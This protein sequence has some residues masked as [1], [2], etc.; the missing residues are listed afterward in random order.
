MIPSNLDEF[1]QVVSSRKTSN[2][3][4]PKSSSDGR[5]GCSQPGSS[6]PGE[7]R[8]QQPSVSN[9]VSST[10]TGTGGMSR[11]PPKAPCNLSPIDR[12]RIITE[13][14]G[15]KFI[16]GSPPKSPV[17]MGGRPSEGAQNAAGTPS[18]QRS[19]SSTKQLYYPPSYN[20][21][22][23]DS[24]NNG[25]NRTSPGYYNNNIWNFAKTQTTLSAEKIPSA[26][27]LSAKL[28]RACTFH[29]LESPGNGRNQGTDTPGMIAERT[30]NY[31]QN[32]IV[33]DSRKGSVPSSKFV[34]QLP[35]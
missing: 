25:S 16:V 1:G 17:Q 5:T 20:R 28:S 22:R 30:A 6:S 13:S 26:I 15:V 2:T 7:H 29:H 34:I 4:S 18:I 19:N 23:S 21:K 9:A 10:P 11:T 8:Q 3:S 33:S 35:H 12:H 27:D 24:E 14:Q 31:L 32:Q